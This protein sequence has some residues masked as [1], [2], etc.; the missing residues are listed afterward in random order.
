MNEAAAGLGHSENSDASAAGREAAQFAVRGLGGDESP[1]PDLL[2]VFCTARLDAAQLTDGIREVVAAEVPLLGGNANG[3]IS[4]D[5]IGYDGFQVAVLALRL[6]GVDVD[7]L[8]HTGVAFQEEEAGRSVGEKIAA[9]L[10]KKDN[11]DGERSLLFFY[12][13]VNRLKGHFVMNLAT[14]M[15]RGM[16]EHLDPWPATAGARMM[17][18]MKF[19]PTHQWCG[20]DL[21]QDSIVALLLTGNLKMHTTVLHGCTPTSAYHTV[22]KADGPLLLEIDGR[23]ALEVIGD[24]LGPDLKG[25]H[26]KYKFFVTL[27]V[28]HGDKWEPFHGEHYANRMCVGV[29]AKRGGLILA[30]PFEEGTQVQ[31]MRRNLDFAYNQ[32]QAGALIESIE[33]E[34]RKPLFGLY[35]NCAGRAAAYYGSDEQEEASFVQAAVDDRFPLLGIYEA[36]E[37][38]QFHDEMHLTDWSGIFN[39][40]SV[41]SAS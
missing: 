3:I 6:P 32:E 27:G 36:G 10:A 30:E 26:D 29:N 17:G 16:S 35:I 37:I 33:G 21:L 5:F 22:T 39:V 41:P 15:L 28:N 4:N 38:A 23:P 8:A 14:P 25:D 31:L 13:C 7:L 40:F 19:N 24:I 34:R 9:H 11:D 18:D 1:D 2:L 12:D 20:G